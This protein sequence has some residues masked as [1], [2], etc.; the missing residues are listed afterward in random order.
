MIIMLITIIYD[1]N[2]W[3]EFMMENNYDVDD[4]HDNNIDDVNGDNN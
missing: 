2:L 3:W 1:E 4:N